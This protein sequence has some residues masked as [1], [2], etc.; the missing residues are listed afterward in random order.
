MFIFAF[1]LHKIAGVI[2]VV[3]SELSPPLRNDV[4][5]VGPVKRNTN[6]LAVCVNVLN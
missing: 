3:S 4:V 2:K 6:R 1:G 5:S